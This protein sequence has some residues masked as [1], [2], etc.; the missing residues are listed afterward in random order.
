M[1]FGYLFFNKVENTDNL[2][3]HGISIDMIYEYSLHIDDAVT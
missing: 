1:K 3:W 2:E